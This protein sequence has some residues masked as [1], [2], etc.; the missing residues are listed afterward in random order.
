M[1]KDEAF[2]PMSIGLFGSKVEMPAAT[3]N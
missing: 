1:K 3:N 2:N